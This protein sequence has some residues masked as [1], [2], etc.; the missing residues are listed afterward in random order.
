MKKRLLLGVIALFV[1]PFA[2][3]GYNLSDYDSDLRPGNMDTVFGYLHFEDC[4]RDVE[5]YDK[6]YSESQDRLDSALRKLVSTQEEKV[7]L[8]KRRH[9]NRMEDVREYYTNQ[10][11]D[12]IERAQDQNYEFINPN[13]SEEV[14]SEVVSKTPSKVELEARIQELQ[15]LLIQLLTQLAA[16]LSQ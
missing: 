14:E 4:E 8:E 11:D 6:I 15:L 13:E 5:A 12:C 3:H 2:V 16:Q 9:S 10:F 7:S 1:I